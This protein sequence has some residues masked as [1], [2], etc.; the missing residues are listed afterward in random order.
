MGLL[1]KITSTNSEKP[2]FSTF[3]KKYGF[4]HAGIF[5]IVDGMYILK[6]VCG[7]D[8]ETIFKSFSS[9]D[10]WNGII[11]QSDKWIDFNKEDKSINCFYQFFSEEAKDYLY[12]IHFLRF[13][14]NDET[15]Y[16]A[17]IE[18][19]NDSSIHT[20]K[21]NISEYFISDLVFNTQYFFSVNNNFD[22]L[23]EKISSNLDT[24]SCTLARLSFAD[25]FCKL[26]ENNKLV[27]ENL[28]KT[29]ENTLFEEIVFLFSEALDEFNISLPKSN[30]EFR[31]ALFSGSILSG[32]LLHCQFMQ[33]LQPIFNSI[34]ED[35]VFVHIVGFT[36]D[37]SEIKKFLLEA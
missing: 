18:Y 34:I 17:F 21:P 8:A 3:C 36:K 29:V 35:S 32:S 27:T 30:F 23:E 24:N 12:S 20:E 14:N 9:P 19:K 26:E 28:S 10:F 5:G 2:C 4:L 33:L 15:L 31:I 13:I 16:F 11:T 7:I 37:S 22:S 25:L 6:K 1:N